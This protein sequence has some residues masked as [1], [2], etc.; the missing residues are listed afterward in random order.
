MQPLTRLE[1]GKKILRNLGIFFPTNNLST[2]FGIPGMIVLRQNYT[3]IKEPVYSTRRLHLDTPG[4][5]TGL[6]FFIDR[7]SNLIYILI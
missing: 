4:V 2:D 3:P 6:N 1:D 7:G 5:V